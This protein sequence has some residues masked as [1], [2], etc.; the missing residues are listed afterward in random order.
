MF[1]LPAYLRFRG[2]PP[3]LTIYY[4]LSAVSRVHNMATF[5]SNIS[6]CWK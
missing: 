5:M 1:E 6:E 2:Y 3:Q 4:H